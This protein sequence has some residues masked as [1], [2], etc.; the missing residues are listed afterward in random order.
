[1]NSKGRSVNLIFINIQCGFS[2]IEML[3][4]LVI[5]SIASLGLG[6]LVSFTTNQNMQLLQRIEILNMQQSFL[7]L[8]SSKAQCDCTFANLNWN[9]SGDK[10]SGITSIKNGCGSGNLF[11]TTSNNDLVGSIDIVNIQTTGTNRYH[12]DLKISPRSP[13]SYLAKTRPIFISN[14]QFSID[15]D[16]KK[17]KECLSLDSS[18]I[19]SSSS[20]PPLTPDELCKILNWNWNSSTNSCSPTHRV[21]SFNCSLDGSSNVFRGLQFAGWD[22]FAGN[23]GGE[24][25]CESLTMPSRETI[26]V[27]SNESPPPGGSSAGHVWIGGSFAVDKSTPICPNCFMEGS[28]GTPGSKCVVDPG[29]DHTST[30][31]LTRGSKYVCQ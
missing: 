8:I 26:I 22:L 9:P 20:T 30:C 17:I 12:A 6:S 23:V 14:L 15:P 1:M 7:R 25:V 13:V 5:L 11:S 29:W 3:V 28:C 24:A 31:P 18:V 2:L 21:G 4:T 27:Y 19:S 16:S 10:I